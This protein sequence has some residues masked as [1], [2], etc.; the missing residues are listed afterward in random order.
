M[1]FRSR[2]NNQSIRRRPNGN[3]NGRSA[4]NSGLGQTLYRGAAALNIPATTTAT[5][6]TLDSLVTGGGST[7]LSNLGDLFQEYRF[8]D[9]SITLYPAATSVAGS[10]IAMG[11]QNES[12][13]TAPTSTGQVISM[14]FNQIMTD[15]MTTPVR[16]RV[17]RYAL[18]RDG[19]QKFW[20]TQ[21]PSQTNTGTGTLP[22]SNLWESVQGVFWFIA[23]VAMT[24]TA[25]VK[26][27]LRLA[28]PVPLSINPRPRVRT[29][30]LLG[31]K[32]VPLDEVSPN[33]H[34]FS[35]TGAGAV[36]PHCEDEIQLDKN[37]DACD[38]AC[39]R[40]FCNCRFYLRTANGKVRNK[41]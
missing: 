13:D 22:T 33:S 15:T 18:I 25:V 40:G 29:E 19:I 2:R 4:R 38:A 14:P 10:T 23:S 32:F 39:P 6:L 31:W 8:E 12:T 34:R 20:R 11:Y 27:A 30:S 7:F 37:S 16:F 36:P 24:V 41:A 17:P 5:S 1:L 28:N 35:S 3:L 21:L 26:Y 9:L